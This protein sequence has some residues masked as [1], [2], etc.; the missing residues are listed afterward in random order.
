MAKRVQH[1][2]LNNVAICCPEMLRSFGIM[3]TNGQPNIE[4]KIS[5]GHLSFKLLGLGIF[6]VKENNSILA[7]FF[8]RRLLHRSS[9]VFDLNKHL[10]SVCNHL[11]SFSGLIS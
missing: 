9:H 3:Q 5:P 2:A 10:A 1:V 8:I 4:M 11:L 6:T 7:P